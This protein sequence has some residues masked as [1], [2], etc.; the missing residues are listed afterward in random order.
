MSIGHLTITGMKICIAIYK[1]IERGNKWKRNNP[2]KVREYQ[3]NRKRN[4]SE[5]VKEVKKEYQKECRKIEIYCDTCTCPVKKCN[6]DGQ[7]SK[8]ILTQ[9]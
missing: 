1:C 6:I 9:K 3:Q 2:E 4:L 7:N 5:E 8:H